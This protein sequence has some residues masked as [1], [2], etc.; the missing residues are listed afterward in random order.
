M[1]RWFG[2]LVLGWGLL[3]GGAALAAFDGAKLADAVKAA[4]Q[5]LAR[6]KGSETT[7]QVPRQTD[8]AVNALLNAAFST[9]P[10]GTETVALSD[11]GKVGELLGNGNRV[12]LT[13]LLAGTGTADPGKLASDPKALERADK[14]VVTF[15]P[16]V[17]RWLDFQIAVQ[18]ALAD[19]TLAFL[20]SASQEVRDRPAVKSGL[21]Q[22]AGGVAGS[23]SGMLQTMGTAGLNDAWRAARLRALEP[24]VPKAARLVTPSDAVVLQTQ[25]NALVPLIKD[26]AVQAQ[27]RDFAARI[28]VRQP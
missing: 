6:A 14:N 22:V 13:Y 24:V 5:F 12:G 27:L 10:L 11:S 23:L 9:A 21:A 1:G 2:A 8:P 18:G 7:G 17:G 20:A 26:A 15:A 16:E 25:A 19:S 3:A 4:D 28:V